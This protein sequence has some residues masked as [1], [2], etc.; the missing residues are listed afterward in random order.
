MVVTLLGSYGC[1]GADLND[2]GAYVNGYAINILSAQESP[3]RC[4]CNSCDGSITLATEAQNGFPGM[5]LGGEN[6]FSVTSFYDVS[7]LNSAQL[8]VYYSPNVNGFSGV[9][10][11]ATFY[12]GGT[13]STRTPGQCG[14]RTVRTMLVGTTMRF[15]FRDPLPSQSGLVTAEF[16]FFGRYFGDGTCSDHASMSVYMGRISRIFFFFFFPFCCLLFL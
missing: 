14:E 12:T 3:V 16:E 8:T 6:N 2:L 15:S 5:N 11:N 4:E 13:T 10:V 1:D 9:T 7:C